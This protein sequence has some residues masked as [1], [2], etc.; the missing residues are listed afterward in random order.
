MD[1]FTVGKANQF[2]EKGPQSIEFTT[3][4]MAPESPAGVDNSGE[5]FSATLGKAIDKVNS[6]Q[7]EAN[8]KIQDFAVGKNTNIA[9]VMTTAEKAGIAFK[10]MVQVRNKMIDAY[11]EVMRMQV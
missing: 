4:R 8:H 3:Q 6:M 1:G 9:D 7:V 11:H 10:L 5:S 2:L